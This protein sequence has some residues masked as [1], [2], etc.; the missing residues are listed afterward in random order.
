M[1]KRTRSTG[2]DASVSEGSASTSSRGLQRAGIRRR[3][4]WSIITII[5]IY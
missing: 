1:R 4:P 3:A 2:T 5:L